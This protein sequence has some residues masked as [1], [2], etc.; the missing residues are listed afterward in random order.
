MTTE[1]HGISRKA[2]TLL[3][4]TV[5]AATIVT[6]LLSLGWFLFAARSAWVPI[7]THAASTDVAGQFP[8]GKRR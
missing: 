4:I 1:V 7:V 8:D 2:L 5:F 6:G 3:S